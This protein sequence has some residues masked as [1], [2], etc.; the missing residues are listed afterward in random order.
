MAEEVTGLWY[1]S[2]DGECFDVGPYGSRD[3][4]I[5]AGVKM[6]RDVARPQGAIWNDLFSLSRAADEPTFYVGR[7]VDY[8][9]TID[10]DMV[11]EWLQSDAYEEGGECSDGWLDD[12]TSEERDKLQRALQTALDRW[13][14]YTKNEPDFFM[15]PNVSEVDPRDHRPAEAG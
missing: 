2:R 15:V 3:E 7:R 11:I 13:I 12:V 4:A 8:V 1:L 10:A 14:K 9:P 6:Y 5:N